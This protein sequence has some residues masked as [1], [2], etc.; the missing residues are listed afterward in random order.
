M[1]SVHNKRYAEEVDSSAC[2]R[3]ASRSRSRSLSRSRSRSRKR[4]RNPAG[5]KKS[6][7][8]KCPKGSRRQKDGKCH[9]MG[10]PVS[11][12]KRSQSSKRKLAG[13]KRPQSSKKKLA[14][15]NNS[16]SSKKKQSQ[17]RTVVQAT[18]KKHIQKAVNKAVYAVM[19][20]MRGKCK[21]MK[22][23]TSKK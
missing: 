16:K 7:K 14:G 11:A 13:K 9:K 1:Y 8:K 10:R 18:V 17:S 6:G 2:S 3:S 22:K 12:K 5:I 23:K 19:K 21:S 15:R 20:C 4:S